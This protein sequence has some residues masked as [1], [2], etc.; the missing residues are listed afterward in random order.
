LGERPYRDVTPDRSDSDSKTKK[1]F[2]KGRTAKSNRSTS[3]SD[4]DDSSSGE[5]S[6]RE[7]DSFLKQAKAL[8]TENQLHIL[9]MAIEAERGKKVDLGNEED[10]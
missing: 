9:Q 4:A 2:I 3:G 10:F 7:V 8:K 1:T 5:E 6:D